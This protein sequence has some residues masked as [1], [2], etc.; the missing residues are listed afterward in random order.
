M[1]KFMLF[2]L[3][4]T[5][6]MALAL[7]TGGIEGI[8][9]ISGTHSQRGAYTGEL[10]IRSRVA[11]P[12]EAIKIITYKNFKFENLQVQE[13]WTGEVKET[14]PNLVIKYALRRGD[15]IVRLNDERRNTEDFKTPLEVE[16][17]Y[18]LNKGVHTTN[19]TYSEKL[20][21]KGALK[22]EPIWKNLRANLPAPGEKIPTWLKPFIKITTKRTGFNDDPYVKSFKHREEF[23]K[24]TP[25]IV[26]DPTDY[27]FYQSNRE[28]L[29]VV[30]KVVDTI[31]MTESLNRR[32][33]Y[34][35][36]LEEK[37]HSYE[38]NMQARHLPENTGIITSSQ[39]DDQKKFLQYAADFSGGLWSGLYAGSQAMRYLTTQDPEALENFKR[40]LKG[41]FILLDITNDPGQFARS[42]APYD[43]SKK[44]EG[45]IR[46]TGEYTNLMYL[47]KGNNDMVKGITHS[48]MWATY[49]IPEE[50][51]E[52]WDLMKQKSLQLLKLDLLEDKKQNQPSA[53]G[54]AAIIHKDKK[55]EEKFRDLF[56][57][58]KIMLGGYSFDT[59]FYVRGS[60]DW[61]GINLGVVG[62]ITEIM[63]AKKLGAEHISKQV[64][65]RLMDSW[66]TYESSRRALVSVASYAFAYK[67][68]I[69]G[70]K[71]K[72]MKNNEAK[73]KD[74]LAQAQWVLRSVPVSRP[75]LDVEIDHSMKPEWCLSPVP[76]LFW[77]GFASPPPPPSY[78]YQGLYDYPLFE[79]KSYFSTYMWKDGAFSFKGSASKNMEHSGADFLY[80]YWLSQYAGLDWK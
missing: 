67:K 37:A 39:M 33:A 63:V 38:K 55:L 76:K 53:V 23:K 75:L 50:D 30:N 25:Y 68:G 9:S 74:G 56:K 4:S 14:S 26:F 22:S 54:V 70:P 40:V 16:E 27:E 60:A 47:P 7:G 72:D 69:R 73:W 79:L 66:V 24:I 59:T 3:L 5:S 71:F 28:V 52:T 8:Y 19:G 41:M 45:W 36:S 20:T 12:L 44:S 2:I 48:L 10:E 65:E 15:Y 49:V 21:S 11:G 13:V 62:A 80:L 46:G 6:K 42:I 64:S 31:S 18:L 32:N 35:Y 34:A 78:F 77:K 61:S 17:K 43:E 51:T 58:P 1:F 29:R 57:N